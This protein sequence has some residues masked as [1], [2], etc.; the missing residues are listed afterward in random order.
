MQLTIDLPDALPDERVGSII[1]QLKKMFV[2]EG[3]EARIAEKTTSVEKDSWDDL[4]IDT[5]A[6]DTGRE[7]FAE[8][9]DHYLYGV[10]K[11]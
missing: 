9:H 1:R 5:L 11:R 4:D 6:V 7:D 8:N 3:M 2:Q 10:L